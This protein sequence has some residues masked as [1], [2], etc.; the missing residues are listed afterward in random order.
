MSYHVPLVA[1]EETLLVFRSPISQPLPSEVQETCGCPVPTVI[2]IEDDV[3]MTVVP[4][5]NEEV[6]PVQ[7][8]RPPTYA[9][10]LQ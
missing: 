8:E 6:I 2:T 7:V 10:G 3:E 9:V 1:L 4:R 5:E